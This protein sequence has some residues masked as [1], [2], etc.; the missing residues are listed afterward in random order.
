MNRY[1][2]EMSYEFNAQFDY[3]SEAYAATALDPA[4]EGW[5]DYCNDCSQT[6]EEPLGFDVW[7]RSVTRPVA[8]P[9]RATYADDDEIP[10]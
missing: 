2:E 1:E 8:A 9:F 6:G 5:C 4:Y 3:V 7:K 10:F